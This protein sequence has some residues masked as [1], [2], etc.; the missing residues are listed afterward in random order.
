MT[1]F[2]SLIA[3]KPKLS[4]GDPVWVIGRYANDWSGVAYVVG[5]Q[6]NHPEGRIGKSNW[7]FSIMSEEEINGGFNCTD[8]FTEDDLVLVEALTEE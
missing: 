3:S 4:I 1:E 5:I 6:F 7:N 8:G 2:Q